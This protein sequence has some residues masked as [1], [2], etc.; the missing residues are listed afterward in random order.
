MS[1]IFLGFA[2]ADSM[3]GSS[4]TIKKESLSI[5]AIKELINNNGSVNSCCNPSHVATL[6]ALKARYGCVVPVPEK[7]PQVSLKV[8]DSVV[9]LSVRGLPRLDASRHEYTSEE[10]EKASFAFS[11]YTVLE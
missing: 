11:K 8:G 9:V 7:A 1:T 2:V 4:A 6:D 5:E 10:I 3:F